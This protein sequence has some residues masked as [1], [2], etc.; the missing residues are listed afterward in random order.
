MQ[1]NPQSVST[2]ILFT[3]FYQLTMAQ[4]YFRLGLHERTVQFDHFFRRYPDY[5]SH[6]AGYCVAAGLETL[7]DWM[8]EV[9]FGDDEIA[10]LRAQRTSSG[11]AMFGEDFLAWLRSAGDFSKLSLRAIPEGRV[12][13]PQVP[14]TMVQGPLALAQILETPLLNMLNHQT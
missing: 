8:Q 1:P 5:G 14:M 10:V 12:V 13:H 9:R 3:D 11:E 4:V 6:Q 7:V 2:G